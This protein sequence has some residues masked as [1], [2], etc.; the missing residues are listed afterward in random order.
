MQIP[1]ELPQFDQEN[2]LLIVTGRLQGLFYFVNQGKIKKI[3]SF[4]FPNPKTQY[5]DEEGHFATR[6]GGGK[7]PGEKVSGSVL[8][9]KKQRL[10]QELYRK[11]QNNLKQ[12]IKDHKIER[13]YIFAPEFLLKQLKAEAKEILPNKLKKKIIFSFAGNYT[14]YTPLELLKKIKTRRQKKG[15]QEITKP[16]K[17][18]ARKLYKKAIKATK[19]IKGTPSKTN[20]YKKIK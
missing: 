3:K 4:E 7:R 10:R 2:T 1:K 13:I 16:I 6:S 14:N 17:K 8:E 19:V 20:P 15:K 18:E 11:F 12:I 9:P 5:T